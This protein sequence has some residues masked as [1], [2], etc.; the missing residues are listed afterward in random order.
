MKRFHFSR[1]YP[2]LFLSLLVISWSPDQESC[3]GIFICQSGAF[4]KKSLKFMTTKTGI[5]RIYMWVL[6]STSTLPAN[7]PLLLTK[8][9]ERCDWVAN[10]AKCVNCIIHFLITSIGVHIMVPRDYLLNIY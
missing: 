8:K 9:S 10:L 6:T 5:W 4:M 3:L 2:F 7:H 1:N